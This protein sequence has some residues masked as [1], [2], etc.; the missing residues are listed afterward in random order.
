TCQGDTTYIRGLSGQRQRV[1]GHGHVAPGAA[2]FRRT[3]VPSATV[4]VPDKKGTGQTGPGQALVTH[5]PADTT[6]MP[7]CRRAPPQAQRALWLSAEQRRGQ[8]AESRRVGSA[9]VSLAGWRAA[10]SR[11]SRG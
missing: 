2:E 10:R 9:Q 1:P 6:H 11:W 5:P 8:Y 7:G 4:T 3:R